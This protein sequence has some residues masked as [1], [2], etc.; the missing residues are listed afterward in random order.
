MLGSCILLLG[1]AEHRNC[2]PGLRDQRYIEHPDGKSD[3]DHCMLNVAS[4][5]DGS[6][7]RMISAITPCLTH[8]AGHRLE[9]LTMKYLLA[10]LFLPLLL[11]WHELLL[12]S[13]ESGLL[14]TRKERVRQPSACL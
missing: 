10:H 8:M 1:P 14:L 12:M 11:T 9:A 6:L 4:P 13:S 2:S 3:V 7:G 5:W